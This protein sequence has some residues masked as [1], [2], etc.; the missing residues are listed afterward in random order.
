MQCGRLSPQMYYVP[1]C[2]HQTWRL[3]QT[4]T[5]RLQTPPHYKHPLSWPDSTKIRLQQNTQNK[6]DLIYRITQPVLYKSHLSL[7]RTHFFLLTNLL[8]AFDHERRARLITADSRMLFR[9][10]HTQKQRSIATVDAVW[11]GGRTTI[12]F[13]ATRKLRCLSRTWK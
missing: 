2:P 11:G 7:L 5:N 12:Q 13:D 6:F 1:W 10:R 9:E 4:H 3:P 8:A